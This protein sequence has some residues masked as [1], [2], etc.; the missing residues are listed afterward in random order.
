MDWKTGRVPSER[1]MPAV[2]LQ[3]AV[4]R[5]AWA[6]VLAARR[7]GHVPP[8]EVRAAFHYVRSGRTVEPTD[9]PDADELL[10][11][12]SDGPGRLLSG[13]RG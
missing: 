10:R 11:L 2:A 1:D 7:G 5:Y 3:L 4:Y 6:Q 9:L 8:D 13:D 12:L